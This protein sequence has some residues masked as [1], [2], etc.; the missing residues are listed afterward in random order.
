MEYT[1]CTKKERPDLTEQ[2]QILNN[3]AW[4]KFVNGEKVM[5]SYWGFIEDKFPDHQLLVIVDDKVVAFINAAAFLFDQPNNE[6]N[7]GGIY[8]GLNKI[9]HD[10]YKGNPSNTMMALQAIV[11]PDFKGCGLSYV[12]VK[13]MLKLAQRKNYSRLVIPLRPSMK[14][15][16]PL[17]STTE[18]MKW[19]NEKGEPY[20]PWLRVHKNLGAQLVKK[21]KGITVSADKQQWEQWTGLKF[22]SKGK[23]IVP[24]GLNTIQ[25]E[26]D[27]EPITY[28]QEN[29]WA[30]HTIKGNL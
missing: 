4:P 5:R 25:F 11:N 28:T 15:N 13:E 26:G 20:D 12:C 19:E 9:S 1:I 8:W 16:Y 14:N 2:V 7:D 10:F 24:G 30:I 18:Y 29:V 6:I 22:H 23:Y 3:T 21:C 17:I 27:K